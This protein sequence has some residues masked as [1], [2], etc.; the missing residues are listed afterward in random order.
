WPLQTERIFTVPLLHKHDA[1]AGC[2]PP[3]HGEGSAVRVRQRITAR[4]APRRFAPTIPTRG[5][6]EPSSLLALIPLRL[7]KRS[8][9]RG[10]VALRRQA[11]RDHFLQ[12]AVLD[13]LVGRR[14]RVPPPAVLLH[15]PCGG[16][17]TIGHRLKV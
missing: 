16:Y 12:D 5:R 9:R 17:E 11:V 8:A 6:V 14:R 13:R 7:N 1:R 2:S 4:P 15:G 3:P 10:I